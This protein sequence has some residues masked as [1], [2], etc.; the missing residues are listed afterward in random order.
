MSQGTSG[1]RGAQKERF[2]FTAMTPRGQ[3][4]LKSAPY[5]EYRDG[6]LIIARETEATKVM[7]HVD[8]LEVHMSY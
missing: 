7:D 8:T 4:Q 2:L 5:G 3:E 6:H 1:I